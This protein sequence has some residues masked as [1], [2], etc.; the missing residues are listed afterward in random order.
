[1]ETKVI[2]IAS[3]HA[4]FEL[5]QRIMDWL[6]SNGYIYKDFGAY[7]TE[8]VDYPDFGHPLAL[9]VENG[10]CYPGIALCGT[11]NGINIVLNKHQG[12]RAVLCW[13]PEIARLCRAHNDANILT[14]PARFLTEQEVLEIVSTFLETPFEGGRHALR[15][16]KIP[17]M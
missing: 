13:T 1:M 10:D 5:K 9:A 6:D 3:D 7:S 8:S 15:I 11:G 4:G 17:C 16:Q 12:V 14:L 2:G